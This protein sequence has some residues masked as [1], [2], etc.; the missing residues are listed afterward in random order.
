M[1]KYQNL[2]LSLKNNDIQ[3]FNLYLKDISQNELSLNEDEILFRCI[4]DKKY[5]FIDLILDKK[6]NEFIYINF[7][8]LIKD[9]LIND[10]LELIK[11]LYEKINKINYIDF[12]DILFRSIKK[13]SNKVFNYLID[14]LDLNY[15][16]YDLWK[17]FYQLLNLKKKEK[18]FFILNNHISLYKY[19]KNSNGET[20]YV[21]NFMNE[22]YEI[23]KN[24]NIIEIKDIFE[25][26]FI[27]KKDNY[28]H[29][30]NSLYK[31]E[32]LNE[33]IF[34]YLYNKIEFIITNEEIY[35]L[36]YESC[37]NDNLNLYLMIKEKL[38]KS[39]DEMIDVLK[40]I[41]NKFLKR[42]NII[43]SFINCFG[44]KVSY[45]F[46]NQLKKELINENINDI[47][48]ICI[49][50]NN[51]NILKD[52]QISTLK[53]NSNK[54]KMNLLTIIENK[55]INIE[56]QEYIFSEI[57]ELKDIPFIV[58]YYFGYIMQHEKESILF[59]KLFINNNFNEKEIKQINKK[60]IKNLNNYLYNLIY[61]FSDKYD[62]YFIEWL[63]NEI[64]EIDVYNL[65]YKSVNK[66]NHLL[67]NISFLYWQIEKNINILEEEEIYHELRQNHI[68]GNN[69][70]ITNEYFLKNIQ[71][72]KYL[73]D[74]IKTNLKESLKNKDNDGF[75]ENLFMIDINY[76]LKIEQLDEET[77]KLF[78]EIFNHK[79][80]MTHFFNKTFK[81]YDKEHVNYILKKIKK[82]KI[83]PT[84]DLVKHI[85][86]YD[87]YYLLNRIEKIHENNEELK[88]KLYQNLLKEGLKENNIFIIKWVNNK[89]NHE[90]KQEIIKKNINS[91]V[92]IN[93]IY[94]YLEIIDIFDDSNKF[95]FIIKSLNEI[96]KYYVK[97]YLIEQLINIYIYQIN[98]KKIKI[99]QLFF[100]CIQMFDICYLIEL[101]D[102]CNI[103]IQDYN[104]NELF[105]LNIIKSCHIDKI[106]YLINKGFILNQ[107]KFRD[108]LR[109][110]IENNSLYML[111]KNNIDFIDILKIFKLFNEKIIEFSID[112][113]LLELILFKHK[114]LKMEEE[115]IGF[116]LDECKIEVD[117]QLLL[118]LNL[119]C[120]VS[121]FDFFY[122]R[123]PNINLR[124]NNDELFYTICTGGNIQLAKY[125]LEIQPDINVSKDD[126][127]IF[128]SCCN[129]GNLIMIKWLYSIIPQL[130]EK[131]Y[132]EHSIC[133]A[134]YYGHLHV[135]KWLMKNFEGLDIKVDEDYC[136][137]H[138]VENEYF[139]IV[140][141]I[142]SLEPD[143]YVIKYNET[144]EY[145][146][147]FKINKK[148]VVNGEKKIEVIHECPICYESKS[149]VISCCDH[150]FCYNCMNEYYQKSNYLNCPFCRK[151]KIKL[152]YI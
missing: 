121:L 111:I 54:I 95:N 59:I 82:F 84:K 109:L 70:N 105:Q 123:N 31:I 149:N 76:L 61:D 12:N 33:D 136:M 100:K 6:K 126:D 112:R 97:N 78:Q 24:Y 25:K 118:S 47:I 48:N 135:A 85:I 64:K 30:F 119:K 67:M 107:D 36:I 113:S 102:K 75:I 8:E 73:Q 57:N 79:Q 55:Y 116:L 108:Q 134:C 10:N 13:K 27:N 114:K 69:N 131:A 137:I 99:D 90:I 103:K 129:E 74:R 15:D 41:N 37:V 42:R 133:G 19:Y 2:I 43:E 115:D 132:Y 120:S 21:Y 148:L 18:A 138:A 1:E 28:L 66:D 7:D 77:N 139:D 125:L 60:I 94:S 127:V 81:S 5:E 58:D 140:D 144:Y 53:Y 152:Y 93:N 56:T 4:N 3:N 46:Y 65:I 39:D 45:Y 40:N 151:E 22:I 68:L 117:Y 96:E 110:L 122:K 71:F 142:K 35:K 98:Q 101:V 87:N 51:I 92:E 38:K 86:Y 63:N 141:W 20:E 11:I 14:K 104:D 106:K 44:E 9:L 143:R 83:S 80:M 88:D 16:F 50:K 29:I 72:D 34:N 124:E 146:D 17:I 150:Q 147:E 32:E 23:I 49:K 52:I 145:I 91:H 26:I 130:S 128:S 62:W 89:Y